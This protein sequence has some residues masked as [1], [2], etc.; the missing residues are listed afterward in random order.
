MF[1]S[2]LLKEVLKIAK[3]TGWIITVL[4]LLLILAQLIP[5]TFNGMWF[6]WLI[7]LIVLSV[8]VEKL[9]RAYSK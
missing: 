1:A 7:A 9:I 8:G 2:K 5:T 4:G 6:D 3:I